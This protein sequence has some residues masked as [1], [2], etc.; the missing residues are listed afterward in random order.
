MLKAARPARIQ[1]AL[2]DHY[3]SA[4]AFWNAVEAQVRR[5]KRRRRRA[6]C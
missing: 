3:G 6:K 4:R 1:K 5:I 2:I